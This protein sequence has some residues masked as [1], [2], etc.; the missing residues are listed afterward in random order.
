LPEFQFHNFEI[1]GDNFGNSTKKCWELRVLPNLLD[2][3]HQQ[4]INKVAKVPKKQHSLETVKTP[5]RRKNPELS[6]NQK[7]QE[8]ARVVW[9]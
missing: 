9:N 4:E 6:K 5:E 3:E 7:S 8:K 1:H 2:L